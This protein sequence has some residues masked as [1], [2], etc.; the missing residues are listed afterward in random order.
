MPCAHYDD[1][2][3]A[4]RQIEVPTV[5]SR[6]AR[7]KIPEG[8]ETGKR[9]RLRRKGNAGASLQID[10]R[11]YVQVEVET[12]QSLTRKQKELFKEFEK[13]STDQTHPETVGS[14]DKVKVFW[15]RMGKA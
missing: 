15:D 3:G 2:G 8:T 9:F 7:V 14:L 11:L 6:H 4:R 10:R 12:P 1:D 5:N 13:V